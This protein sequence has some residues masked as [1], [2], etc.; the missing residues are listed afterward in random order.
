MNEEK[1]SDMFAEFL[2]S[3]NQGGQD[4]KQLYE[5]MPYLNNEQQR[6][7]TV[8]NTLAKKYNSPVLKEMSDSI[9]EYARTNRKLGFRFTRL[10]ESM[11]LYKHFKGY[12]AS[13]QMGGDDK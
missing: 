2:Q 9:V 10:I 5:V 11:A 1:V 8:I 3:G 12:K 7:L 4:I 13:A 6:M